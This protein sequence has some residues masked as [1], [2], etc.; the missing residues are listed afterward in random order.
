MR[1]HETDHARTAVIITITGLVF[2]LDLLTPPVVAVW[3]L[4]VLPLGLGRWSSWGAFTFIL[5]GTS[6]VLIMLGHL[7]SLSDNS[8]PDIALVNRTLGVAMVWIAAFFL[9]VGKT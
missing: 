4:Y 3:A 2:V 9:Q 7:Y 6:T 8:T 1:D 5:A